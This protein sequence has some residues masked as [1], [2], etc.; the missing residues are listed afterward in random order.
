MECNCVSIVKVETK[1]Y[2]NKKNTKKEEEK[3]IWWSRNT[4]TWVFPI[5]CIFFINFF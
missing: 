4:K 1:M 3:R 2:I 5:Y